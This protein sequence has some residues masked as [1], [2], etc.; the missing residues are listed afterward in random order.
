MQL[1]GKFM[2]RIKQLVSLFAMLVFFTLPIFTAENKKI[3]VKAV[4]INDGKK[5]GDVIAS[6]T[7]S[8]FSVIDSSSWEGKVTTIGEVVEQE[9]G[10]QIRST[11]GLGS[12]SEVSLRG[13]DSDQVLIYV[14]G[15]L[16]NGAGGLGVDLSTISISD[17]DKIEIYRG[18]TPINFGKSSIGGIINIKT[19]RQK[20]GFSSSAGIGY[21][22]F[23]T[24]NGVVSLNHKI[25]NFDYLINFDYKQSD[26]DFTFYND[27]IHKQ[28]T[29]KRNNS[30]FRSGNLLLKNGYDLSKDVRFDL[31][32]QLFIKNQQIPNWDNDPLL[33]VNFSSLRDIL[34]LKY[35]VNNLLKKGIN[36]SGKFDYLYLKEEY[37]DS[38][39]QIGLGRQHNEYY[40]GYIGYN[41]FIELNFES[42]ILR[43]VFD[44]K[45]E[46]YYSK[47]LIFDSTNDK[48]T[49][50]TG[51][52]AI[53]NSWFF[54]EESLIVEPAF[55]YSLT[56][57]K[58]ISESVFV[59]TRKITHD[60]LNPQLGVKYSLNKNLTVKTN[61]A[62]YVR[63]PSL[64]ELFGDRGN[65]VGN[66][67]LIA[68]KG[69][70]VD[71][72]FE[73]KQ[74][75]KKKLF[76]KVKVGITFFGSDVTD[77]IVHVYDARGVG[78]AVNLSAARVFGIESFFTLNFTSFSLLD[79]KYTW[80]HSEDLGEDTSTN[81]RRL[82]GRY[83][84]SV[85]SKLEIGNKKYKFFAK[86][87]FENGIYYDSPNLLSAKKSFETS[88][89]SSVKWNSFLFVFEGK[90]I[91]NERVED[92]NGFPKPG[93]SYYLTIKYEMDKK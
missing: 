79:V 6:E 55:R 48:S 86:N 91:F 50:Q 61:G 11:G 87:R 45:D 93:R 82:P 90:N 76:H 30:F 53:S 75:F 57:D 3:I 71:F 81:G 54:L 15:V 64:F 40:S 88:L 35:T 85:T 58:R 10:V 41:H 34:S 73:Y 42:S 16:L 28:L 84:H 49:R 38:D 39:N 78:R 51:S 27:K 31:S 63:E 52:F 37:D 36:T 18:I 26:N 22:S 43:T 70:N 25:E 77:A 65:F 67:D 24:S 29:E 83:E 89:G 68:E 8:S 21:G 14:D 60:Y 47:D 80:Q 9:T 56:Y 1:R 5:T 12:Y 20:K 66:D 4:S 72:G 46:Y 92:F 32:N 7:T 59:E 17:V 23:N 62:R 44:Y 74:K 13:S 2:R 19:K 69:T 33:D